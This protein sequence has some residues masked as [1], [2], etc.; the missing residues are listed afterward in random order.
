MLRQLSSF[1]F[2]NASN[3]RIVATFIG[4]VILG[5]GLTGLRLSGLGNDPCTAFHLAVSEFLD[6]GL[7]NYQLA[8][9]SLMLIVEITFGR[10]YIGFATIV[11]MTALGYI[12]DFLTPLIGSTVGTA[13]GAGFGYQLV[14][15]GVSLMFLSLGVSMY[16]LGAMGLAPYD[17]LSVGLSEGYKFKYF[18]CRMLT[19]CTC[20]GMVVLM[21]SFALV[22]WQDCHLG[23]GTVLS[24]LCLGPFINAFNKVNVLWI[25]N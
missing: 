21:V 11:N 14:Y 2:K 1:L 19:D 7:G 6:I 4:T 12:I 9:N 25:K 17:Y 15:M 3:S 5:L 10:K 16:Q 18:W 22:S 13:I 8:V 20:C 23:I 24:A